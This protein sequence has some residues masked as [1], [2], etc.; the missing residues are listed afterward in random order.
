VK[1]GNNMG[2]KVKISAA[3]KTR[4]T[5]GSKG[6]KPSS[7]LRN[8]LIGTA[9]VLLFGLALAGTAGF[10]VYGLGMA[11]TTPVMIVLAAATA[12]VLL[13]GA[14]IG[15]GINR[16][17]KRRKIKSEKQRNSP[18]NFV[19]TEAFLNDLAAQPENS[20]ERE[21]MQRQAAQALIAQQKNNNS[22]FEQNMGVY[23]QYAT[24]NNF[25]HRNEL[26]EKPKTLSQAIV[27]YPYDSLELAL[28]AIS[29][30][31]NIDMKSYRPQAQTNQEQTENPQ[32]NNDEMLKPHYE[33]VVSYYLKLAL[34]ANKL[35]LAQHIVSN[36]R[37]PRGFSKELN[38]DS[39]LKDLISN[40]APVSVIRGLLS[41]KQSERST[42]PLVNPNAEFTLEAQTALQIALFKQ[43]VAVNMLLDSPDLKLIDLLKEFGAATSGY[44]T[45]S[46]ARLQELPALVLPASIEINTLTLSPTE[47]WMLQQLQANIQSMV[48]GYRLA[49][50]QSELNEAFEKNMPRL[51]EL[52]DGAI[53]HNYLNLLAASINTLCDYKLGPLLL[54]KAK[55]TSLSILDK[56]LAMKNT[57]A[58]IPVILRVLTE[59]LADKKRHL[60]EPRIIREWFGSIA[61]QVLDIVDIDLLTAICSVESLG[62]ELLVY[63]NIPKE[64]RS[65]TSG[66]TGFMVFLDKKAAEL[67]VEQLTQLLNL[68]YGPNQNRKAILVDA[69]IDHYFGL[70]KG[71]RPLTAF[72]LLIQK[73]GEVSGQKREHLWGLAKCLLDHGAA[74]DYGLLGNNGFQPCIGEFQAWSRSAA[75]ATEPVGLDAKLP[76]S[77]KA[78]IGEFDPNFEESE[79]EEEQPV[80]VSLGSALEEE[81]PDSVV[82]PLMVGA[83]SDPMAVLDE[84]TVCGRLTQLIQAGVHPRNV[85][86][87]DT[88]LP[89]S[90]QDLAHIQMARALILVENSQKDLYYY[91]LNKALQEQALN[92]LP[93][94]VENLNFLTSFAK[95][96]KAYAEMANELVKGYSYA[97]REIETG[98]ATTLERLPFNE[99]KRDGLVALIEVQRE[100][101]VSEQRQ[102]E[103]IASHIRTLLAFQNYK[104]IKCL[105]AKYSDFPAHQ[106]QTE[107]LSLIQSGNIEEDNLSKIKSILE[108]KQYDPRWLSNVFQSTLTKNLVSD[109]S[110][111]PNTNL[112]MARLLYEAGAEDIN[113]LVIKMGFKK[114][115]DRFNKYYDEY[116]AQ[117]SPVGPE[118]DA[119]P[120]TPTP[121]RS[122]H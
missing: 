121:G 13:L 50:S 90:Y 27:E 17:L 55:D 75:L 119:V 53:K 10:A 56:I 112:V 16:V 34:E 84:A 28:D 95:E 3:Q 15:L 5:L 8:A 102:Q 52:F 63:F 92:N 4:R 42:T 65:D 31:I 114:V 97:A 44:D 49:S 93:L 29:E 61:E 116:E 60:V 36:Y 25:F 14:G 99:P 86:F 117:H 48:T 80:P 98:T 68:K 89:F 57:Q 87:S 41:L 107:L 70:S 83:G 2:K 40:N 39:M 38:F 115:C 113:N 32:A 22:L 6:E 122:P 18:L 76:H 51:T 7:A 91:V 47:Q 74:E 79:D 62:S 21:S 82:S 81:A 58:L 101:A 69:K 33:T 104:M 19:L 1:P 59:D 30:L 12:G 73:S 43:N 9:L 64:S 37:V 106:L 118:V 109:T 45:Q 88:L 110:E 54:E 71:F 20:L 72:Q 111:V 105:I 11:L 96:N 103:I 67:S 46:I 35:E 78:P 120:K 100:S 66:K 23:Q 26:D 24:K 85:G 94:C 77:Q 108:L